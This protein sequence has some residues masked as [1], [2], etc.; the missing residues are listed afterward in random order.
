MTAPRSTLL[1]VH[2]AADLYGF[3]ITLLQLVSGLD[4]EDSMPSWLFLM[5]ARSF[6][7]CSGRRRGLRPPRPSGTPTPVHECGGVFH[8]ALSLRSI[9][10]LVNLIRERKVALVHANGLGVLPAGLATRLVGCAWVWHVHEIVI[11]PRIV[12]SLLATLSS[13]ASNVVI[14]NSRATAEHYR[15]TRFASSAPIEVILNGV[16]ESRLCGSVEDP[17][18]SLDRSGA[19]GH[20]FHPRWAYKPLE[21]ALRFPRCSGALC[22]RVRECSLFDRWRQLRRPGVANR[23]RRPSH[24]DFGYPSW[25]D[26]PPPS[27]GRGGQRVRGIRCGSCA[28]DRARAFRPRRCGGHGGG[29]TGDRLADR[30]SPRDSR[31]SSHRSPRRPG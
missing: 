17:L 6:H 3:D 7:A 30:G 29:A 14:A 15:Q 20:G 31:R 22:G 11:Q 12:A 9:W 13:A 8:L 10:W 26:G 21:G 1:F 4:R 16:D 19:G 24:R 25:A 2:G 27:R 18:R 28:L 5:T 23:G